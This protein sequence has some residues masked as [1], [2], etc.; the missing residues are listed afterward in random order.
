MNE[1]QE[2]KSTLGGVLEANDWQEISRLCSES[3]INY[4]KS[5]LVRLEKGSPPTPS[6]SLYGEEGQATLARWLA[7]LEKLPLPTWIVEYEK[8]R[9]AK[10][11]PQGGIPRWETV[12]DDFLLYRTANREVKH[13][14]SRALQTVRNRFK[15]LKASPLGQR[16]V[17]SHLVRTNKI[18]SR[19][20]GWNTFQLKKTDEE[21]QA[22]ALRLA[23]NGQYLEGYGYVFTR[24]VK[25]KNRIFMPMPFSLML[26][27]A[28]Y[29]VPIMTK[30]Q[31]SLLMEEV[32]SPWTAYADKVG[33]EKCFKIMETEIA[34]RH[35]PGATIVYFMNDF[36]KMDTCT[37]ADQYSRFVVP[38]FESAC[39]AGGKPMEEA[40]MATV[41]TPIVTPSG[42]MR[43]PHGTASGA[44]V[45]NF[46][47][48]ICNDYF[49][50]RLLELLG[51]YD[52]KQAWQVLS[53][54]LN[55]DDSIVVFDLDETITPYATFAERLMAAAEQVSD[56]TGLRIQTSKSDVSTEMGRFCQHC[57]W[58]ADGKLQVYYP[59]VLALNS[60]CNPTKQYAK[61]AWDKDYRDIDVVEKL[62]NTQW[63]S[64]FHEF[65]DFVSGG[66]KYPLLGQ[67]EAETARILS[68]YDKYRAQQSLSDRY[69]RQNYKLTES[70][71]LAYVLSKR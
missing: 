55:G 33:F 21:A 1:N 18:E 43:G 70:P 66:L 26:V 47:E 56:E 20:A 48:C 69:N 49:L 71:T 12:M 5:S 11:A 32:H 16:E 4:L 24:L 15:T 10:F 63:N 19:A 22:E 28:Q 65:V 30:I 14:S 13:I 61:A 51:Y 39:P 44:E 38:T 3:S 17:L 2:G 67:T 36:E 35:K 53:V 54:R 41:N 59:T 58:F 34:S 57:L 6:F 68:K 29:F 45:T 27:Q 37:A 62:D 52:K 23:S 7:A 46:G 9:A 40:L 31:A 50:E 25:T 8:S 42:T 60:I 64:N